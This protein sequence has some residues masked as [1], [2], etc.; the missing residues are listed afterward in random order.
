MRLQNNF[1]HHVFFYLKNHNA[2]NVQ[3]LVDGLQKLSAASTIKQ[4]HIG[5]PADTYRD[6]VE[7]AYGVSWL[8]L[9]DNPA[10]QESYQ[11][12]PMHLEFIDQCSHLW[13]RVVVYDSVNA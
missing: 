2:G 7:R 10:D 12:D 9:F 8:V 4:F 5:I 1:V 3:S 13:N 11:T 6:V